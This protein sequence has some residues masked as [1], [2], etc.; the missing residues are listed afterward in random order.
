MK[1]GYIKFY[2]RGAAVGKVLCFVYEGMADFEVTYTLYRLKQSGGREIISIGYDLEPVR[3]LTGFRHV[4]DMTVM[5]AFMLEDVEA[6]IIPGG[7]IR[8]QKEDITRL[9]RKVHE[10]GKLVAAI[11]FGPQF[12][13]RSGLLDNHRFTTSCSAEVIRSLGMADPFPW[14][15]YVEERAVRD[16]NVITA[17]GYA[18]VDFAFKIFEQLGIFEDREMKRLYNEVRG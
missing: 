4:P 7:S 9:I 13:G 3:G 14:K 17:K 11:C 16:G 1:T 6:L 15:N 2:T 18:F 5:D 10:E 8:E 12:L